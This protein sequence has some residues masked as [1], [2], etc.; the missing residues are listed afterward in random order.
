MVL[1]A[2]GG[3]NLKTTLIV[4]LHRSFGHTNVPVG[5]CSEPEQGTDGASTEN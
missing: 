4:L 1:K 5:F 2:V 3:I